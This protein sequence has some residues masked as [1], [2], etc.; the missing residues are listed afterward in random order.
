MPIIIR[1]REEKCRFCVVPYENLREATLIPDMKVIGVRNLQ[2]MIRYVQS[3]DSYR[4]E[5][6]KTIESPGKEKLDSVIFEDRK[7]E[8]SRGD[9]SQRFSQSAYD[10]ASGGRKNDGCEKNSGNYAGTYI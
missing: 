4:K 10:R 7:S 5:V 6:G 3:P 2:E 8:T 1:A 9:C